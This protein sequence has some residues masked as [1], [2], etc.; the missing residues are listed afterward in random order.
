[1]RPVS[2]RSVWNTGLCIRPCCIDLKN[3]SI[4]RILVELIMLAAIRASFRSLLPLRGILPPGPPPP[5]GP[6]VVNGVATM[7]IRCPRVGEDVM[8]ETE[9]RGIDMIADVV[10][11]VQKLET[12]DSQPSLRVPISSLRFRTSRLRFQNSRLRFQNSRLRFQN[13][14]PRF[15][16]PRL[17]FQSSRPDFG[18]HARLYGCTAVRLYGCPAAYLYGC[19][20]ARL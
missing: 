20:A 11:G 2:R 1:M 9:W 6:K 16:N 19:T 7:D 12:C 10:G 14:S 4:F 8:G 5:A 18:T 15:Q 3:L 13:P 17:R